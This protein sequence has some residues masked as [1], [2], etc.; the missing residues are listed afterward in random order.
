MS[1]QEARAVCRHTRVLYSL[2]ALLLMLAAVLIFE[3]YASVA[4]QWLPPSYEPENVPG[5]LLPAKPEKKQI[6]LIT[7]GRSGSTFTSAIISHPNSVFYTAEPLHRM[8]DSYG[9]Y[10]RPL[11]ERT[12]LKALDMIRAFLECDFRA[13][14][15]QTYSSIMFLSSN[16]TYDFKRC[17]ENQKKAGVS[18]VGC[19]LHMWDLCTASNVTYVKTIRVRMWWA[20]WFLD[21]MPNLKVLFLIRDPRATLY[22][23]AANFQ[24]FDPNKSAAP[25][26]KEFCDEVRGDVSSFQN[27]SSLYPG[28]LMAIRYEDGAVEPMRFAKNIYKFLG[29]EF[30]RDME[31][32]VTR[33]VSSSK[34][35]KKLEENSYGYEKKNS[36]ATMNRWRKKAEFKT[37]QAFDES[38]KDLYPLFGYRQIDSDELLKSDS[39]LL[40]SPSFHGFFKPL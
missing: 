6:L 26:S 4:H 21:R 25:K 12:R 34:S 39:S 33:I 9:I 24:N 13:I 36:T 32:F 40:T 22:S 19:F 8:P 18:Y 37:V 27:L 7:Y 16:S 15:P 38:C 17:I 1:D 31:E 20:A 30:D 29:N 5:K 35:G 14:D 3:L 10:D 11:P 28:R 2:K 23:Q